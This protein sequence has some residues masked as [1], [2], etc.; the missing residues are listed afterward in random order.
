MSDLPRPSLRDHAR[1]AVRRQIAATAVELF[2]ERGFANVTIE[3]IVTAAG[4]SPRTFHRY[5]SAKEETV[6]IDAETHGTQVRDALE[7]QDLADPW[8][9]LRGS[10]E[11][12]V[13]NTAHDDGRSLRGMRVMLSAPTLRARNL[14]KHREW[15][16]FLIPALGQSDLARARALV[17]GALSCF[18]AALETWVEQ[19]G[20]EPLAT[21]LNRAFDAVGYR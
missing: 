19:D 5:F 14:Q 20:V 8:A 3:D 13:R 1:D 9:A 2:D 21:I 11:P 10:L 12:L 18:D 15:A 7:R 17:F 16:E 4:T 6:L